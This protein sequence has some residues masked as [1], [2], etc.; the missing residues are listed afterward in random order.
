MIKSTAQ[1]LALHCRLLNFTS[2]I[3]NNYPC[4]KRKVIQLTN[5]SLRKYS[6]TTGQQHEESDTKKDDFSAWSASENEHEEE[7]KMKL[8]ILESAL[9]HVNSKG[10]S[11]DSLKAGKTHIN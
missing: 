1:T 9:N 4:L 10:W 5:P 3:K 11:T 2:Q 7:F 6:N 8:K